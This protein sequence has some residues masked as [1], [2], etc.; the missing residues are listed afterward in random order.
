MSICG[1]SQKQEIEPLTTKEG[2]TDNYAH[3]TKT[4]YKDDFGYV[5]ITTYS[6]L[7]RYDGYEITRFNQVT[8]SPNDLP[9]KRLSTI[10]GDKNGNLWLGTDINEVIFYDRKDETFTKLS[11]LVDNK[12]L[13]ILGLV[14][15][16]QVDN[17][18]QLLI[19][20]GSN[21]VHHYDPN[22]RLIKK[23][24]YLKKNN[25]RL[26][27]YRFEKIL[28]NGDIIIGAEDLLT[29][30][31]D[32][33]IQ[34]SDVNIFR[35][36]ELPNRKL[37]YYGSNS[38]SRFI[39]DLDTDQELSFGPEEDIS[40][41]FVENG[42]GYDLYGVTLRKSPV[43]QDGKMDLATTFGNEEL[44]DLIF[45]ICYDLSGDIIYSSAFNGAGK[46][47]KNNEILQKNMLP[48]LTLLKK[49]EDSVYTS[50]Y[51]TIGSFY[52]DSIT[53]FIMETL[54]L[55]Q[56]QGAWNICKDVHG[57][58]IVNNDANPVTTSIYSSSGLTI[59][60]TFRS[61]LHDQ[62]E[63]LL[64]GNV[65]VDSRQGPKSED[66]PVTFIG[67]YY[68]A[69]SG[70]PYPQ[71]RVR[72]FY[73]SS[74]HD[75][76]MSTLN[77]DLIRV[78]DNYQKYEFVKPDP[79]VK[80]KLRNSVIYYIY[81][82]YGKVYFCNET[83]VDVYDI[84]TNLYDHI[85]LKTGSS[86]FYVKGMIHDDQGQIWMMDY[87]ILYCYNPEDKT[88]KKFRIPE[89]YKIYV[90]PCKD[91]IFQEN[92]ILYKS[93]DGI[94]TL[95]LQKLTEIRMPEN[96]VF[97]DLFIDRRKVFPNDNTGILDSSLLFQ[98]DFELQFNQRNVGFKFVS[99]DSKELFAEYEYRLIGLFDEWTNI[100]E[101][102]VVNF[103]NLSPGD[104]EFEVRVQSSAGKSSVSTS[105]RSFRVFAPWYATWL[106]YFIYISIIG[107]II[108]TIYR[109][110]INKIRE[111]EQLRSK[112]SN[113]LH[114]DVGGLLTG[115]SMQSELLEMSL[116]GKQKNLARKIKKLGQKA[117]SS[118]RDT[119]WAIDASKDDILS[120]IDRMKD[121]AEM[122]LGAAELSILYD[123][124]LKDD[125]QIL[126]PI[127]RQQTYL[128]FKEV[129][130]NAAKH[131]NGD[132]VVVNLKVEKKSLQ[133][134]V[135]DNGTVEK[136]KTSGLG[137]SSIKNRAKSINGKL[138]IDTEN[139]FKTK[140]EVAWT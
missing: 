135:Q 25:I 66:S 118:M 53:P 11:E 79:R 20:T 109:L 116:D 28:R 129:I 134:E 72:Y 140:F 6:G 115:L 31:G 55:N 137:L 50:A 65:A 47:V 98:S 10:T 68:E 4:L 92:K 89:E 133:L 121:H 61:T 33:I 95:D 112:I 43:F 7:N 71:Y 97:Q 2:L 26:P 93:T 127:I 131:T 73:Q 45:D 136:I 3:Y 132:T 76:W 138:D 16:L 100:E 123:I 40:K 102:R 38:D 117:L 9:V 8:V 13:P 36:L 62:M 125:K 124:Q 110:K 39:Y 81:E 113:D 14:N 1:S 35:V 130:T 108:Y 34:L 86:P 90:N 17:E 27:Y 85:D 32:S 59:Q 30:K 12:P 19:Y 91:L 29:I 139:G 22:T 111:Q 75:I 106:A 83:G 69:L 74:N 18:G 58:M 44:P 46:I 122:T 94:I 42:A 15:I 70:E 5:W 37:F 24:E 41:Y 80:D 87:N 120:L 128:I 104:Y 96:V 107:S 84:K 54:E 64:D 48:D 103:T 52:Q 126:S 67:E 77:G 99:I 82:A 51:G 114:D 21:G 88:V 101:E 23:L 78:Y 119:V 49:I 63:L 105:R 57:N 56:K 60:K